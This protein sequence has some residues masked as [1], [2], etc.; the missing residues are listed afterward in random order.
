MPAAEDQPRAI[1]VLNRSELEKVG[2]FLMI[3][4]SR[5]LPDIR[6][7]QRIPCTTPRPEDTKMDIKE[8][9]TNATKED[10]AARTQERIRKLSDCRGLLDTSQIDD[11]TEGYIK[12]GY[13]QWFESQER[14]LQEIEQNPQ[15]RL[16]GEGNWYQERFKVWIPPISLEQAVEMV[17]QELVIAQAALGK[18]GIVG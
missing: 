14:Y 17:N 1:E 13:K 7:G 4:V 9:K 2:T 6:L 18:I 5:A 11:E 10:V 15:R 3:G 16:V 8:G 12:Y